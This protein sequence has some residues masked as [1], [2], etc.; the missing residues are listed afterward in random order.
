MWGAVPFKETLNVLS[1]KGQA[2]LFSSSDKL[3]VAWEDCFQ[4]CALSR[5]VAIVYR[6]DEDM[7]SIMLVRR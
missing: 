6:T 2:A 4:L 5:L 1:M 3:L 7:Q